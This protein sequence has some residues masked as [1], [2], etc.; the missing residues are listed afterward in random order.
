MNLH[1]ILYDRL[2]SPDSTMEPH[3]RQCNERFPNMDFAKF[4][5]ISLDLQIL[6]PCSAVLQCFLL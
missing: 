2:S 4:H 6:K 3:I 1:E 5:K